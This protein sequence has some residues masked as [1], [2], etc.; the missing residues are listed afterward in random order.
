MSGHGN[1]K[2]SI[3]DLRNG[4]CFFYDQ[5]HEAGIEIWKVND[6]FIL[7]DIPLFGGNPTF[8]K[9]FHVGK[10]DEMIKDYT[11]LT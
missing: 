5:G 8:Y 4:E 1:N 6:Y 3:L 11:S 9:M 7:F 10:I 2:K